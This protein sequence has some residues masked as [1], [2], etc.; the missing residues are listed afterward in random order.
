MS[1]RKGSVILNVQLAYKPT[2][3]STK[4][5]EVF[6]KAIQGPIQ[7]SRIQRLVGEVLSLRTEKV[8]L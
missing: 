6:T 7:S 5:F 2:I 8:I 3:S 1:A 4:A